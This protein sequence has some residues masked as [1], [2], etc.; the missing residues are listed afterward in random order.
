MG[1]ERHCWLLFNIWSLFFI[2]INPSYFNYILLIM[3]LQLSQFSSLPLSTQ[4][5]ALPQDIPTPLFMSMA[6]KCISSLIP[7]FPILYF[8]FTWLFCNYLFILLNSLTSSP[9]PLYPLPSGNHQNTLHD[10]FC[11]HDSVSVLSL[12][13]VCFLDS[14]VDRYV[15]IAILLLVFL[16]F[17]KNKSL[18][19]FI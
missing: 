12:C 15:F 10:V 2:Q 17:F 11:F 19:Y 4:H 13:L 9:I 14:V 18:Q 1:E 6:H 16:I 5:T 7:L 3:L 8:I